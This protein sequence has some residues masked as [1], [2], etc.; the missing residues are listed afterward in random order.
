MQ[1]Q[2][3]CILVTDLAQ[4]IAVR[5]LPTIAIVWVGGVSLAVGVALD[6]S[7]TQRRYGS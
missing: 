3:K 1:L 2:I 4:D 7:I 6:L 5:S